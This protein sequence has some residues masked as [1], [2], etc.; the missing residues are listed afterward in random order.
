[1]KRPG[2]WCPDYTPT[3][4]A[5]WGGRGSAWCPLSAS[6]AQRTALRPSSLALASCPSFCSW[7]SSLP[8]CLERTFVISPPGQLL[9][10]SQHSYTPSPRISSPT[11]SFPAAAPQTPQESLSRHPFPSVCI[12]TVW[13][14]LIYSCVAYYLFPPNKISP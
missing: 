3:Q 12:A 7:L 10:I 1:M 11:I 8:S 5:L 6:P 9:N 2:P 4:K 13:Q 14:Y